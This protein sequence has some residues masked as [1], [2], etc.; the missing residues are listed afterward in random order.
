MFWWLAKAIVLLVFVFL[1]T[2]VVFF[3]CIGFFGKYFVLTI[4]KDSWVAKSDSKL[5]QRLLHRFM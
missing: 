4:D 5:I 3:L 2:L 1:I